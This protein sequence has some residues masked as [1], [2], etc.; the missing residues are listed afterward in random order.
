MTRVTVLLFV[1]ITA[2]P[3]IA[4]AEKT[5]RDYPVVT[6]SSFTEDNGAKA[7]QLSAV[8]DAP[9][10]DVYGAFT[11]AS[12]FSQWA[13]AQARID[14]RVGGYIESSYDRT[15]TL[16]DDTTIKN[17]ILAYVPDRVLV[18]RN[19][20]APKDF[21]SAELFQKTVTII[22]FLAIDPAQTRVSITNVGYGVSDEF[23]TLA[24]HFEWGNAYTLQALHDWFAKKARR[25]AS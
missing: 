20:R 18:I 7:I 23:S 12:E 5:W 19:V 15:A 22:E 25:R 8:V 17:E 4:V 1:A 10:H 24:R 3:A 11:S 9:A 14:F 2:L 21:K 6:N 16:G 13:V